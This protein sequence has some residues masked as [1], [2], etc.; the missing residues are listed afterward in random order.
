MWSCSH[1]LQ[2]TL[3]MACKFLSL[4]GIVQLVRVSESLDVARSYSQQENLF[5]SMLSRRLKTIISVDSGTCFKKIFFVFSFMQQ[6]G[7]F[8]IAAQIIFFSKAISRSI[9]SV[10]PKSFLGF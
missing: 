7:K 4:I 6:A 3:H 1:V 5:S 10:F 9:G 8:E 2:N